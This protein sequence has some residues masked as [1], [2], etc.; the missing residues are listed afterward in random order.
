MENEFRWREQWAEM[1]KK[2]DEA[3][4]EANRLKMLKEEAEED[5]NKAEKEKE[6]K[7][8]EFKQQLVE[9]KEKAAKKAKKQHEN[10]INRLKVQLQNER[11]KREARQK[12]TLVCRNGINNPL[13]LHQ[14]MNVEGLETAEDII[15]LI[16]K[17]HEEILA[18][19]VVLPLA[20]VKCLKLF[21]QDAKSL[22]KRNLKKYLKLEPHH[23]ERHRRQYPDISAAFR[24]NLRYIAKLLLI[25]RSKLFEINKGLTFAEAFITINKPI[26]EHT[27]KAKM[28]LAHADLKDL[29][30]MWKSILSEAY[31]FQDDTEFKHDIKYHNN[32]NS[33][34]NENNC[35]LI[36]YHNNNNYKDGVQAF[37]RTPRQ[38]NSQYKYNNNNDNNHNK[39]YQHNNNNS[40]NN[41]RKH[42]IKPVHSESP[43]TK[44]FKSAEKQEI[45]DQITAQNWD[46]D[47]VKTVVIDLGVDSWERMNQFKR[48]VNTF[49]KYI[50]PFHRQHF[51]QKIR[52]FTGKH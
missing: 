51:R 32:N 34:D 7:E 1:Q 5:K 21:V 13:T 9:V 18:E 33:N 52:Q 38:Y 8:I 28:M 46:D 25:Y 27:H 31:M 12:L 6:D 4:A 37:Y 19:Y 2:L 22:C 16:V 50:K 30:P 10:E 43:P 40:H 35:E 47:Y 41:G 17:A 15:S 24:K 20:M 39:F 3:K 11:K 42:R 14:A 26:A 44:R 49:N 29:H 36:M 45:V 23:M 48:D